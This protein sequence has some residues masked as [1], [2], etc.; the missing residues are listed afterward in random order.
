MHES[1]Q[2]KQLDF[3]SPTRQHSL[4]LSKNFSACDFSH[5]LKAE[6]VSGPPASPVVQNTVKE[7]HF[8]LAACKVSN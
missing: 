2:Q 5:G 8:S 7:A 4:E 3:A 6:Q 1:G